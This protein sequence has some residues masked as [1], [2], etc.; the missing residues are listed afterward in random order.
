MGRLQHFFTFGHQ[1]LLPGRE[2]VVQR[3]QELKES[4]GKIL[5]RIQIGGSEIHLL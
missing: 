2:L 5:L 4:A 3:Q 1:L